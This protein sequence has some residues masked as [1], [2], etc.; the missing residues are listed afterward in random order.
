[1]LSEAECD[2]ISAAVAKAELRSSGEIVTIV[3]ERSDAYHD[4]A[5]HWAIL[6]MLLTVALVGL[7]PDPL[8]DRIVLVAGGWGEVDQRGRQM[9][10]LIG[11]MIIAFLMVRLLLAIRPLRHRL[12]PKRTAIRRVRRRAVDLF[13]AAGRGR[14]TG[15]TAVLLYLSL[16]ERRAELVVDETIHGRV[17]QSA[18][19]VA[20]TTLIEAVREGRAGDGMVAAVGQIGDVLALHCPR[21]EDDRNELPDRVITL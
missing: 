6:A 3:A 8:Y 11:S 16:A 17:E 12:I 7:L 19:E 20:M 18:W 9:A 21:S 1:M 15:R 4:V 13:R 2:Q 10:L 5:L 14:T